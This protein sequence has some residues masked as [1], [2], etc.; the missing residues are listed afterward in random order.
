MSSAL[1]SI[2]RFVLRTSVTPMENECVPAF[3]TESELLS[4]IHFTMNHAKP[5]IK[6]HNWML[7]YPF[8][9]SFNTVEWQLISPQPVL[10]SLQEVEVFVILFRQQ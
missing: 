2:K 1:N 5:S 3:C 9:P 8:E 4:R 10:V 7:I 6:K